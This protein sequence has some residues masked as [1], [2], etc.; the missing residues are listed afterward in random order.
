MR[1]GVVGVVGRLDW[2]AWFGG[3]I[4][5]GWL[6]VACGLYGGVAAVGCGQ[7]GRGGVWTVC[8]AVD[9]VAVDGVA[10][11]RA[12]VDRAAVHSA[13]VHSRTAAAVALCE[14]SEAD[15]VALIAHRPRIP[16]PNGTERYI[17]VLQLWMPVPA[18]MALGYCILY[19]T[20]ACEGT[21]ASCAATV[22]YIA[23]VLRG[24]HTVR[25]W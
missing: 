1:C 8:V 22:L 2:I 18:A 16:R 25:Q 9:G 4:A 3:V 7:C 14:R 23:V 21:A 12:A 19:W 13:A 10:V 20:S 5:S 15:R 6:L 17:L 11:D 24:C